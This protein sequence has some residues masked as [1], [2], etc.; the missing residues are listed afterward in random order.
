MNRKLGIIAL[1]GFKAKCETTIYLT[2]SKQWVFWVRKVPTARCV[3]KYQT[4]NS[5]MAHAHTIQSA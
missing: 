3:Q 4:I 2:K 1:M 5:E